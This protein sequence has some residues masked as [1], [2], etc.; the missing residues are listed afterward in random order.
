MCSLWFTYIQPQDI[1]VCA[2][3]GSVSNPELTGT[4]NSNINPLS[5]R[6]TRSTVAVSE[7][8]SIP[9]HP[10]VSEPDDATSITDNSDDIV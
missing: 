2:T 3:Y 10:I 1:T 8:L 9:L 6:D 5:T 4:H 7:W